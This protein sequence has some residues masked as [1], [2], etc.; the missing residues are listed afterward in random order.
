MSPSRRGCLARAGWWPVSWLGRFAWAWFVWAGAVLQAEVAPLTTGAVTEARTEIEILQRWLMALGSPQRIHDVMW[1]DYIMAVDYGNGTPPVTIHVRACADGRYRRDWDLPGR[2]HFTQ[3][4]DGAWAWQNSEVLGFGRQPAATHHA[5][6]A[7]ADLRAPLQA[8]RRYP[9][10]R[11]L[12]DEMID[13]RRLEVLELGTARGEVENWYFDPE[14]GHRVRVVTGGDDPQVVEFSDFRRAQ[15]VR[16][17][18]HI[19]RTSAAGRMEITIQAAVYDDPIDEILFRAPPGPLEDH[20]HIERVLRDYVTLAG[21]PRLK[22]IRT[23]VTHSR[24]ENLTAGGTSELTVYLKQPQRL[25]IRQETPGLGV[26]WQGFNGR[27]GWA[28]NELEGAR[29]MQ[30]A[31]LQQMLGNADLTGPLRLS[32]ACPLRRLL[33]EVQDGDR[34]LT[35]IE[36][37]NLDGKVGTFYF[38]TKT[39]LLVRLDTVVQ[40]G[41][42]GQMTVTV[43]F[44][45]FRDVDDI[46]MPHRTTVTNPAMRIVT[47]IQSVENNVPVDDALFEPR[48]E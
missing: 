4:Y 1:A 41:A 40:S 29:T 33:P 28:W 16:E 15:G 9:N 10:R 35:A 23:R 3:A 17:A 5:N 18:Y 13:G 8:A 14:T 7:L 24:Q 26:A 47:T 27:V 44:A 37:A 6:R 19:V 12:P 46:K 31:E 2:G 20:R 43:D 48:M 11:R 21:L 45:D 36:L 25:A 38:D 32:E 34:W 22:D 39:N 30:G 42:D